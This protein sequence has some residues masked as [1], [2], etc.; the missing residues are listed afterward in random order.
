MKRRSA[1]TNGASLYVP[2]SGAS[3]RGGVC[4][5]HCRV[6]DDRSCRLQTSRLTQCEAFEEI[7]VRG[8]GEDQDLLCFVRFPEKRERTPRRRCY[9]LG[10]RSTHA[11]LTS[12]SAAR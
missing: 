5:N 8:V 2:K 3:D 11:A 10:Y 6:G 12:F 4:H 7:Q 9:W 1:R